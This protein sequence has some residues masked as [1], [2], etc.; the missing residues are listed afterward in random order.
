MSSTNPELP[1]F[2]VTAENE[3]TEGAIE[4]AQVAPEEALETENGKLISTIQQTEELT[5]R[6]REKIFQSSELLT[7]HSKNLKEMYPEDHA[8]YLRATLAILEA[9]VEQDAGKMGATE[10]QKWLD[11]I[12]ELRSE[13]DSID[14]LVD[15]ESYYGLGKLRVYKDN[16]NLT[17]TDLE[18]GTILDVGAGSRNFAASCIRYGINVNVYS[19]EPQWQALNGYNRAKQKS[20][21]NKELTPVQRAILDLNTVIA[22]A[23]EMPFPDQSFDLVVMNAGGSYDDE[24]GEE[25]DSSEFL[26]IARI[27]KV[28]GEFRTDAYLESIHEYPKDAPLP[29]GW[30]KHPSESY[31]GMTKFKK[32][33]D[34][35]LEELEKTGKF[36]ITIEPL[37]TRSRV[38]MDAIYKFSRLIIKKI[39]A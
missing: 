24:N 19:L 6:I 12:N 35:Q 23:E 27:L 30:E 18:N 37:H 15:L 16:L 39:S 9:G 28:G 32:K 14:P 26:Q 8:E 34:T 33:Q 31:P 1:K 11:D 29:E 38:N 13:I 22:N 36:K 20:Y 4:T 25:H 2:G 3:I 10:A 21:L 17:D 7:I 5:I